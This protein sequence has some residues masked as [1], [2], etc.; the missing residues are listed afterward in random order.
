MSPSRRPTLK[1][2]AARVAA[3]LTAVVDLPTPPFPEAT[4][5][6]CLMPG[7]GG[8]GG[9]HVGTREHRDSFDGTFRSFGGS[10]G[11]VSGAQIGPLLTGEHDEQVGDLRDVRWPPAF[12]ISSLSLPRSPMKS[13]G[14]L[15]ETTTLWSLIATS[16]SETRPA[17]TMLPLM[18]SAVTLARLA[19]IRVI[20]I[21]HCPPRRRLTW[22]NSGVRQPRW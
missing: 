21:S 18:P 2:S 5:T 20:I 13:P 3:R 16:F 8:L 10:A 7:I 15:T 11:A 14:T 6:M 17:S 19:M 12:S 22:P 9:A 1:P 4:A